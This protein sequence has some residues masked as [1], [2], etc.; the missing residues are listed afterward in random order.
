M[1]ERTDRRGKEGGGRAGQGR[2]R[3]KGQV[4]GGVGEGR[5]QEGGESRERVTE[6]GGEGEG[7]TPKGQP[8]AIGLGSCLYSW[9]HSDPGSDRTAGGA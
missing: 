4:G 6:P 3:S 8:G 7:E 5:G 9:G 1:V 2:G